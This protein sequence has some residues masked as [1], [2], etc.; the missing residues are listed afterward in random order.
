MRERGFDLG[1]LGAIDWARFDPTRANQAEIDA[2]ELPIGR[3][4]GSLTK[5]EFLEGAHQREMLGYPVSNT[6]DIAT[7][8]QLEARGFWQDLPGPDGHNERH[9][10]CFVVV[11]G[12]RPP[13]L[14]PPEQ[15]EPGRRKAREA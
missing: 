6:A 14:R 5:R 8:P 4:I 9:C 12:V 13:L 7:D 1:P 10:G 3:F 11:D 2:M 15:I